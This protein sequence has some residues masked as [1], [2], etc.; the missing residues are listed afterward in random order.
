MRPELVGVLDALDDLAAQLP[1][2][3]LRAPLSGWSIGEHVAHSVQVADRVLAL[4]RGPT[5]ADPGLTPAGAAQRA[6]LVRGTIPRGAVQASRQVD[7]A[8]VD[9]A[10]VASALATVRASF[11]AA[12]PAAD[13]W[14]AD[15]SLLRHPVLGGLTRAEWLRFL[16][17]HT[18]H[19]RA[20]MADIQA[21]ATTARTS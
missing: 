13:A 12:A 11:H 15:P 14:C 16:E 3:S 9:P 4:L 17:V 20:I 6:F 8:S 10:T 7:P 18:R 5:P 19:H 2:G 21:H 1:V